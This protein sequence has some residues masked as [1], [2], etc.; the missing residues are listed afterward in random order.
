ML[1]TVLE[2]FQTEVKGNRFR[3][4]DCLESRG[5]EGLSLINSLHLEIERCLYSEENKEQINVDVE[6]DGE[7]KD[8]ELEKPILE[9]SG[10]KPNEDYF[11]GDLPEDILSSY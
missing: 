6:P 10:D 4:G 5:N 2:M 8:M 11:Y 7:S 9:A 1:D 3:L